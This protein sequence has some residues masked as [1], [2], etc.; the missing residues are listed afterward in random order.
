[1]RS[2]PIQVTETFFSSDNANGWR[3]EDMFEKNEREFNVKS[4]YSSK[5]EGYTVPLKVDDTKEYR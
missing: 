5:L 1:M 4:T 3:A 2:D